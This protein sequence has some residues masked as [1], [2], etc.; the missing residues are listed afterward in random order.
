MNKFS[1]I[2]AQSCVFDSPAE[3]K[4]RTK[5]GSFATIRSKIM[6]CSDNHYWDQ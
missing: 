2:L 4:I 1:K 5:G 6:D 3:L